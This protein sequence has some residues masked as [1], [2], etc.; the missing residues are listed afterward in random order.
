V[1]ISSSSL[2]NNTATYITP[3]RSPEV[4]SVGTKVRIYGTSDD[5]IYG[6]WPVVASVP[7]DTTFTVKTSNDSRNIVGP[8]PAGTGGTGTYDVAIQA[9]FTPPIGTA[10]QYLI[11]EGA[12]GAETKYAWSMDTYYP[13]D[14]PNYFTWDDWGATM[15][16]GV[17]WPAWVPNTPPSTSVPDTLVTTVTSGGASPLTLATAPSTSNASAITVIDSCPNIIAGFNAAQF[18]G[19]P[20]F[21]AN[22]TNVYAINSFCDLSSYSG[23]GVDQAGQIYEGDTLVWP[24]D[25][26]WRGGITPYLT[27]CP[28]FSLGC[29]VTI[30]TGSG[31]PANIFS[32]GQVDEITFQASGNDYRSMLITGNGIPSFLMSRINFS[33]TGI[34][35]DYTGI[36]LEMWAPYTTG[37]AGFHFEDV[38][39]LIPGRNSSPGSGGSAPCAIIKNYGEGHWLGAFLSH[40]GIFFQPDSQGGGFDLQMRYEDE[41][42]ITPIVATCNK[43]NGLD[44]GLSISGAIPD[45]SR[46]PIA[47]NFCTATPTLAINGSFPG[48]GGPAISGLWSSITWSGTNAPAILTQAGASD[49]TTLRTQGVFWDGFYNTLSV[50]GLTQDFLFDTAHRMIGNG[51][52]VFTNT[53]PPPSTAPTVSVCTAGRGSCPTSP[54]T[55]G[56][57]NFA[58]CAVWADNSLGVCSPFTRAGYTVNGTTQNYE[59]VM[60]A[61]PSSVGAVCWAIASSAYNSIWALSG[62]PCATTTTTFYSNGAGG[63]HDIG[64]VGSALV[65]I[66]GGGP[67]QFGGQN[68]SAAIAQTGSLQVRDSGTCTM[69]A[70]TCAAQ[71]LARTYTNA[72]LCFVQYVSGTLAGIAKCSTSTTTATPNSTV[73][74]DTAVLNWVVLGN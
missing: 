64:N 35:T 24:S 12:T 73:N 61:A 22:G 62:N 26:N 17:T 55:A 29:Y 58:Y 4:L 71:P 27:A 15:M 23:I 38:T 44:V 8:I 48:S 43:T 1:T 50:V 74:T 47:V 20:K 67:V 21:P 42:N 34:A 57:T 2:S 33:G 32:Q 10:L 54:I 53:G 39:C 9:T 18:N 28:Q 45:T 25:V 51:Y 3:A 68:L 37:A 49:N 69:T 40:G 59:V 7:N 56:T 72:P 41:G 14:D 19:E 30:S 6:G 63:V 16:G 52:K 5:G 13:S 66:P 36:P 70:G 11:F 46:E 65:T 31:N 60:P